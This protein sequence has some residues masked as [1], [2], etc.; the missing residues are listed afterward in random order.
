LCCKV[1]DF[2]IELNILKNL[3]ENLK[4]IK[5]NF[6]SNTLAAFGYFVNQNPTISEFIEIVIV[7]ILY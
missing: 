1:I 2:R 3:S 6:F 5:K 7:E 4:R